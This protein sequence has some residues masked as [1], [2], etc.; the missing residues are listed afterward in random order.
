L[1]GGFLYESLD[2]LGFLP[3]FQLDATS[4]AILESS[5]VRESHLS[6]A[7]TSPHLNFCRIE[8]RE[9]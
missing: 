1:L 6:S 4:V 2:G 8:F 5:D 3:A 7:S 9:L